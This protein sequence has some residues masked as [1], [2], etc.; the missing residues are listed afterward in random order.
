V[1]REVKQSPDARSGVLL[2]DIWQG[3]VFNF[4]YSKYVGCLRR[5]Q[6]VLPLYSYSLNLAEPSQGNSV[7]PDAGTMP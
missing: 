3:T 2:A 7:F 1:G 4:F 5:R 6:S